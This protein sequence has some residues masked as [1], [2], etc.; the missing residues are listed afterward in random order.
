MLPTASTDRLIMPMSPEERAA[1]SQRVEEGI[2]SKMLACKR[3]LDLIRTARVVAFPEANRQLAERGMP[4]VTCPPFDIRDFVNSVFSVITS[5]EKLRERFAQDNA[6]LEGCERRIA[7]HDADAAAAAEAQRRE[8]LT[9]TERDI[10]D[11]QREN[12]ELR[13]RDSRR[14][15][16]IDELRS[17]L[18]A[19]SPPPTRAERE[20]QKPVM[21]GFSVADTQTFAA[22]ASFGM[23]RAGGNRKGFQ[24][25]GAVAIPIG[26]GEAPSAKPTMAG[27]PPN[28]GATAGTMA[29][30]ANIATGCTVRSSA[31][32]G[33]VAIGINRGNGVSSRSA[34]PPLSNISAAMKVLP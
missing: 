17:R 33:D 21:P 2:Q 8:K 14:E 15:M 28:F 5:R 13:A 27:L 29:E 24:Y 23:T 10:E 12:A 25:N 30:M 18:P 34:M 1:F 19:S 7:K 31:P 20:A 6:T 11:L 26:H 3:E 4:P 9:Q 32:S 22:P 16:E